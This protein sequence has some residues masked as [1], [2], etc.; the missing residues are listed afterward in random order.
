MWQL[1]S[2]PSIDPCS[3][4][5][6]DE[7]CDHDSN[8]IADECDERP[9]ACAGESPA[10]AEDCAA[11]QIANAAAHGFWWDGN[12][13]AGQCADFELFENEQGSCRGDN[14]RADDAVHAKRLKA[15]HLL[16]AKPRED[17]GTNEH[18]TESGSQQKINR[19][20]SKRR[21]PRVFAFITTTLESRESLLGHRAPITKGRMR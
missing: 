10:N 15:E 3:G 1:G 9:R 11:K 8:S 19:Q 5:R 16:N 12:F 7:R 4:E 2:E 20:E 13:L 6:T 21:R 18:K 17:F 14:G